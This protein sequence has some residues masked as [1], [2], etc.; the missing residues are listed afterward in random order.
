M[1]NNINPYL[2]RIGG[3][4]PGL[5]NRKTKS[6]SDIIDTIT[7][8]VSVAGA[9]NYSLP[10]QVPYPHNITIR[11]TPD[12]SENRLRHVH[13]IIPTTLLSTALKIV[14]DSADHAKDILISYNETN[15]YVTV[16]PGTV[17]ATG[18]LQVLLHDRVLARSA[19]LVDPGSSIVSPLPF[20]I[21]DYTKTWL[22]NNLQYF[23]NPGAFINGPI[24]DIGTNSW[25]A[26]G[27]YASG[28]S[29]ENVRILSKKTFQRD[30]VALS[31]DGFYLLEFK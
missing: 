31:A 2:P 1:S 9:T 30:T 28:Y 25:H 26:Y 27:V 8:N 20:K 29:L 10:F 7:F 13:E 11:Y 17:T 15:N 24:T 12:I 4:L 19:V 22:G 5:P 23:N 18:M 3:G 14:P 6:G 16:T 21:I